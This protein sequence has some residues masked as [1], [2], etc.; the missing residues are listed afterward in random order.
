MGRIVV[1]IGS[2][3]ENGNTHTLAKS[4][5]DGARLNNEVEVIS[6]S[7]YKVNPC[8]GCNSCYTSE[9]N[10]CIQRDDMQII[11]EKIA[12]ADILVIASPVYFYGLSAELK[13]IIDRLHTPIR[14]TFRVK[15][16]ALLLVA[17]TDIPHLFDPIIMQY[18][19]SLSFFH[20]ESLGIIAVGGV[21]DIGD[22]EDNEALAQAFKLGESIKDNRCIP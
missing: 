1:L 11:Y 12:Q 20:L 7:K 5:I 4:F 14:K 9:G 10:R 21:K 19:M 6:V 22:I 18:N 13:A 3:R 15:K 17:A 16:M 2:M 8:L